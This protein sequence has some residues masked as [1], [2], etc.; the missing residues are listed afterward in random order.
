MTVE[1]PPPKSVFLSHSSRDNEF[2]TRLALD[3]TELGVS[4]WYDEWE[5]KVG[6]SLRAKISAGITEKDF[7]AV[8]LSEASVASQWVQIELH[9]ALDRE[10]R[11][12]NVFVL[13]LLINQCDIPLFLRDKKYANF[14]D[15]YQRGLAEIIDVL[16]VPVEAR[17]TRSITPG[18]KAP[19]RRHDELSLTLPA[20]EE[21]YLDLLEQRNDVRNIRFLRNWRDAVLNMT[22]EEKEDELAGQRLAASEDTL[23][24]LEKLA[25]VGNILVRYNQSELFGKLADLLYEAYT[26]INR[27]GEKAGASSDWNVRPSLARCSLMEIV[28]FLGAVMI[29]EH[30]YS[31]LP[32][33]ISRSNPRDGTGLDYWARRSWFRY[34][35]TM[36]A[37]SNKGRSY[38][39][40]PIARAAQ[41][42]EDR[43]LLKR[44]FSVEK[45]PLTL[46][47]EFDLIQCLYWTFNSSDERYDSSYPNCA[48][49]YPSRVEDLLLRI[50]NDKKGFDFLGSFSEEELGDALIAF[51]SATRNRNVDG[52]DGNEWHNPRIAAIVNNARQ[53]Q[54]SAR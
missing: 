28:Y 27:C 16:G 52:W 51:S 34:T 40:L 29:E 37:R 21:W 26:V 5:I 39:F 41:F 44:H 18:P 49:Y 53:R 6:D 13:P 31:W 9:A 45:D 33:L 32:N 7:L 4:V 11:D 35:L 1:P 14:V 20:F 17:H 10:L 36:A 38:W 25:V 43:P 48:H 46:L 47:C 30:K 19:Q 50:L 3:L 54:T 24:L 42:I 12:G 23:S 22:F 15:D 8:V 2:C